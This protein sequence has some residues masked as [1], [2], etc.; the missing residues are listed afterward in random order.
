MRQMLLLGS[1]CELLKDSYNDWQHTET[2]VA[3]KLMQFVLFIYCVD[4]FLDIKLSYLLR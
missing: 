3:E 2:F 4:A 1:K